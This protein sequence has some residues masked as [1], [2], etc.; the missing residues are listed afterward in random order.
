ME[1]NFAQNTTMDMS[2]AYRVFIMRHAQQPK[3][4]K[5]VFH[6]RTVYIASNGIQIYIMDRL[7]SHFVIYKDKT[8]KLS[9]ISIQIVKHGTRMMKRSESP[10]SID[11]VY[12]LRDEVIMYVTINGSD[13][14]T[15]PKLAIK[16]AKNLQDIFLYS[17]YHVDKCSN[18][19]ILTKTNV[20]AMRFRITK[21]TSHLRSFCVPM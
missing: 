8:F 21:A 5:V 3:Q 2:N 15:N 17:L 16:E 1:F 4:Y 18:I 20:G 11:I 6:H 7:V 12:T 9:N 19:L 14:I 10:F 13:H